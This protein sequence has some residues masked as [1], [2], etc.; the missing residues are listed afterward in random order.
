MKYISAILVVVLLV[1]IGYAPCA[2]QEIPSV[3]EG[4]RVRIKTSSSSV[5]NLLVG[6]IVS[7]SPNMLVLKSNKQDIP[8]MIPL[9]S[10]TR[11][12]VSGGKKWNTLRGAGYGLLVGASLG[13]IIGFAA[14]EDCPAPRSRSREPYGFYG[15]IDL[16]FPRGGMAVAEGITFGVVGGVFG[17]FIGS[18]T[19]TDRWEEVPLDRLR[20]S[21]TPQRQGGHALSASFT[22]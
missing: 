9:T 21:L 1:Q 4:D 16:C 2:A 12:E 6:N 8:L 14:G 18:L 3:A 20:L 15:G 7:L 17:A 22:F 5:S 11:L 13:G 10:V 19:L